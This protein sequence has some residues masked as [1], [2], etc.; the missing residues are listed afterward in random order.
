MKYHSLI[1]L[2]LVVHQ[3]YACLPAL[4][5]PASFFNCLLHN[6]I[7]CLK[8]KYRKVC[9]YC[10]VCQSH[11]MTLESRD[12]QFGFETS[13]FRDFC[14]LYEGFIFGEFGLGKKCQFRI[15][16]NWFRKKVSASVSHLILLLLTFA[17]SQAKLAQPKNDFW[18]ERVWIGFCGPTT[19]CG[20]CRRWWMVRCS[21]WLFTKFRE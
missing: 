2:I 18:L 19:N 4:F 12:W 14:Q 9:I 5:R 7:K 3:T 13:R 21:F 6:R 1:P 15:R 20:W 10:P 11:E 17:F 8:E 16:K